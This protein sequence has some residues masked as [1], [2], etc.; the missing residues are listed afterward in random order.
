M[1][2]ETPGATL[3]LLQAEHV[4]LRERLA[5]LIRRTESLYGAADVQGA[6]M[7]LLDDEVS[8]KGLFHH[9]I[10]REE[11]WLFP[12]LDERATEEERRTWLKH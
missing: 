10:G 2:A 6:I 4:K 12:R 9:H 8:F 1:G 7:A 5:D 11:K 3:E